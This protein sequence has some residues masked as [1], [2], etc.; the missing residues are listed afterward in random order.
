MLDIGQNN[1][2]IIEQNK[3]EWLSLSPC[4]NVGKVNNFL[5]FKGYYARKL[6]AFAF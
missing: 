5:Y 2:I 3:E 4:G 6:Y 1:V